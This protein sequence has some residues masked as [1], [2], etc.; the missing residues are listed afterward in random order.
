WDDIG[1][2]ITIEGEVSH[3]GSYGFQ[4]GEHLSDVL[5]RAGGF[6]ETA[7][8]A[9]AV[10]VREQVR[11]LEEKSRVELIRQIE[12]SSAAAR[13]SPNLG[14]NDSGSTLK[15]IQAQQD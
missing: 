10:L 7:Y 13:L 1:A 2:S 3:P 5:R 9:G 4:E 8:P 11:E 15:L 14:S 12:T 6:R